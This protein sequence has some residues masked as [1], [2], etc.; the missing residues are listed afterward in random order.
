MKI[1]LIF[2]FSL[3]LLAFNDSDVVKDPSTPQERTDHWRKSLLDINKNC[4]TPS[5]KEKEC[6]FK[7]N[8]SPFWTASYG[9]DRAA[10]AGDQIFPEIGRSIH[11]AVWSTTLLFN[12]NQEGYWASHSITRDYIRLR[13]SLSKK[14]DR[15]GLSTCQKA[16]LSKC[17]SSRIIDYSSANSRKFDSCYGRIEGRTADCNGF[18]DI[19]DELNYALGVPSRVTL[20]ILYERTTDGRKTKGGH[21]LVQVSMNGKYYKMEPQ[22]GSCSF[23]ENDFKKEMKPIEIII[24]NP[25]KKITPPKHSSGDKVIPENM[26]FSRGISTIH[27]HIKSGYKSIELRNYDDKYQSLQEMINGTANCPHMPDSLN[28]SRRTEENENLSKIY[29]NYLKRNLIDNHTK[30]R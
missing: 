11:S 28:N 27:C 26:R 25:V 18:A 1:I 21:A 5:F 3:S 14:A 7:K 24:L 13:D 12:P 23:F 30:S 4:I 19:G 2:L 29:K 6:I 17:I 9:V 10:A 16:C 22:D 20:G 8:Y 15:E